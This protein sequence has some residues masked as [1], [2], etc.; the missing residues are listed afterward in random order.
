M[1]S[2]LQLLLNTGEG[3]SDGGGCKKL[4]MRGTGWKYRM[5]GTRSAVQELGYKKGS[6]GGGRE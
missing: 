6:G 5:G 2:S 1:N 4:R 3:V